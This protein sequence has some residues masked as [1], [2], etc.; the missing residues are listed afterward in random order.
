MTVDLDKKIA[1][2]YGESELFD[3]EQ[4]IFGSKIYYNIDSEEGLLFDGRTNSK[5][6]IMPVRNSGKLERMS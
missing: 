3:G 5:M 4:K 1:L 2:S 6:D